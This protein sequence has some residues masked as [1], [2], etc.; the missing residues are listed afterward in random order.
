MGARDVRASP[1]VPARNMTGSG[2]NS[3]HAPRMDLFELARTIQHDRDR[4]IEQ[5]V[6]T[7][8]LLARRTDLPG[9]AP[10]AGGRR[11]VERPVTQVVVRSG[12]PR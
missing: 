7:R 3:W 8:R 5:A 12:D 10:A 2:R 9:P 11:T 6:R 1:R 4:S